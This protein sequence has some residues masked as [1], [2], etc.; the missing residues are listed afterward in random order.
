MGGPRGLAQPSRLLA[1]RSRVSQ[2]VGGLAQGGPA[3]LTASPHL[4]DQAQ[5]HGQ[6]DEGG[7]QARH[8]P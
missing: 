5:R 7:H 1:F 8:R 6:D 4:P 3:G 2:L